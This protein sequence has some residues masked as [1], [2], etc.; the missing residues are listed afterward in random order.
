MEKLISHL[1]SKINEILQPYS[2]N[3][4]NV[5]YNISKMISEYLQTK[6]NDKT[7]NSFSLKKIGVDY[8]DNFVDSLFE[9]GVIQICI[10][11]DF[12]TSV[13]VTGNGDFICLPFVNY[14]N[15]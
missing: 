4:Q 10:N 6:I 1:E 12:K 7:I 3:N 14:K 13:I 8:N 9:M 15:E 2:I 11:D 5:I